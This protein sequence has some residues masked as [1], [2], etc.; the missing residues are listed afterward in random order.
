MVRGFAY[1]IW[2]ASRALFIVILLSDYRELHVNCAGSTHSLHSREPRLGR[3]ECRKNSTRPWTQ[4]HP[5]MPTTPPAFPREFLRCVMDCQRLPMST[6]IEAAKALLPFTT[7]YP[8]P[9]NSFRPR[10]TIVIPYQG[11]LD[12]SSSAGDPTGNHS[13]NPSAPNKTLTHGGP[14]GDP[15]KL[16]EEIEA[17]NL[18]PF[19]NYR[20]PPSP[21]ELAEIKAVIN[22]LRPE[23]A[24]LPIPEPRLCQCGHWIFGPCPLGDRCREKS[25]MN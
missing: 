18:E 21:Q 10:C 7:P 17:Q 9:V 6:R 1:H 3:L 2:W 24:D 14:P 13:Q 23:F 15:V 12:H 22:R 5:P 8:R 11:T 19:P 16:R 20:D 25:K 4:D